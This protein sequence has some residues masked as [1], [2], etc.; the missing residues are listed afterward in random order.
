M[1]LSLAWSVSL[2]VPLRGPLGAGWDVSP[3]FAHFVGATMGSA[4]SPL[5]PLAPVL[6]S[7]VQTLGVNT[8]ESLEHGPLVPIHD[9]LRQCEDVL[10]LGGR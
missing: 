9:V 6:G 7:E 5:P 8:E 10:A 4:W 2:G 3:R 1:E